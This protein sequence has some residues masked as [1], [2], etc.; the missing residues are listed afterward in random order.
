MQNHTK[1]PSSYGP[2]RF[3]KSNSNGLCH[4]TYCTPECCLLLGFTPGLTGKQQLQ[5]ESSTSTAKGSS[6]RA[7]KEDFSNYFWMN[8]LLRTCI[9][10]PMDLIL[11]SLQLQEASA[12]VWGQRKRQRKWN[13]TKL[14]QH[15]HI[16]VWWFHL[17]SHIIC[18][19]LEGF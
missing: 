5:R 9:W 8:C 6:S 18:W 4:I 13:S 16:N 7:Y 11:F 17:I 12:T 3:P 10:S 1:S 15:L 19:L 14:T 2:K